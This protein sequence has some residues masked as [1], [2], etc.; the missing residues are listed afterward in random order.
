[1]H[2]TKDYSKSPTKAFD[3]VE[4]IKE[5]LGAERWSVIS[6]EMAK[7]TNPNQFT[8]YCDISGISGYPVEAWY[9]L[10]HG[11][12]AYQKAIATSESYEIQEH[13]DGPVS[14]A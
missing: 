6:P 11:Q 7:V 5:W 10:Y 2:T 4:D 1:M 9:D 12:G 3:A 14:A 8:F 13:G